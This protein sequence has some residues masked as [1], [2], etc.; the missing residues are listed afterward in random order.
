M[1]KDSP[2]KHYTLSMLRPQDENIKYRG[3]KCTEE[4]YVSNQ[5][6]NVYTFNS[7]EP[8]MGHTAIKYYQDCDSSVPHPLAFLI[9]FTLLYSIFLEC[10]F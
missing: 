10:T 8:Q 3:V 6:E 7:W 4:R 1:G 5:L 9:P 2:S